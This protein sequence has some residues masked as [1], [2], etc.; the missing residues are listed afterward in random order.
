MQTD[1]LVVGA[2]PAGMAA[3]L[4]AA[5]LG[6][7]VTVIDDQRTPGGQ[8]YRQPPPEFAVGDWLASP[9][10]QPGK[11]L[12]KDVNQAG[13][14]R[15]VSGACVTGL[16]RPEAEGGSYRV[17]VTQ[18]DRTMEV[19]TKALLLAPGCYDMPVAFP[20]WNLPGVM[21]AGGIQVFLKSQQF[22]PGKQICFAG[23]HPLQLIVADQ[24][25]DAGGSVKELLFL[26]RPGAAMKLLGTPTTL[27]HQF[28]KLKQAADALL[29]LRR[30]GVKVSF[31]ASILRAVGQTQLESIE[32]CP[33]D[34]TGRLRAAM[35]R[36]IQCDR[37]AVCFGFLASSELAR[38]VDA[39]CRWDAARGGWIVSHDEWHQSSLAG[40]YVAGEITGV[41]G[42]EVAQA[43][44][45]L[46][47]MGWALN[48]RR[49]S[50]QVAHQAAASSRRSLARLRR[51]AQV[52]SDIS[53][54]GDLLLRQLLGDDVMLCKCEEVTA[55]EFR[56]AL[57][58]H[59]HVQTASAAK[60]LT[61]TGMGL[62]QGR[63][64]QHMVRR[65]LAQ[66]GS[67]GEAVGGF[68]ARFPAKPIRIDQLTGTDKR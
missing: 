61:R 51:F 27:W 35:S 33:I 6:A 30:A 12:L 16:F 21:S 68:S 57:R 23:S 2:G 41:A 62:C 49:V 38:Q 34:R 10:Y 37:L 43:E 63:Y 13:E 52:L 50:S 65:L 47:A 24:V 29:R 1:F 56:A 25:L 18:A 26:Q 3:A 31:G 19:E 8:V 64:C 36:K 45:H 11:D 20:G 44:G 17:V 9:A 66:G 53:A 7:Q 54:P 60:L 46:A 15:W 28:G 32:V 40:M 4:T 58:A 42:A 59:K 22:I 14:I 48:S 39:D 5:N 67:G 55:G